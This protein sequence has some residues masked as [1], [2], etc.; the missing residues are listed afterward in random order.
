MMRTG[1]VSGPLRR[2]DLAVGV[3]IDEAE[4]AL[5]VG[6]TTAPG[7]RSRPRRVGKEFG[8]AQPAIAVGVET[9]EAGLPHGRGQMGELGQLQLTRGVGIDAGED[10]PQLRLVSRPAI[11]GGGPGTTTD[12]AAALATATPLGRWLGGEEFGQR[13][14]A[15]AIGVELGEALRPTLLTVRRDARLRTASKAE[16]LLGMT[17]STAPGCRLVAGGRRCWSQRRCVGRL[18]RYQAA[19]QEWQTKG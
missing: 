12:P 19:E 2:R 14:P 13:H 15:G 17:T 6:S 18:G 11:A 7:A 10:L 8:L 1:P 5:R 4:D 16:A 9:G 3:A